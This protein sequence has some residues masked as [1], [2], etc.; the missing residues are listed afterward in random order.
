MHSLDFKRII[1]A[2]SSE[3]KVLKYYRPDLDLYIET[4]AS[5]KGIGMALLQS[6]NNECSSLYPIAYGSKTLTSAETR[7]MNIERELL[8][9]VGALEKFHYFTFG[10]PVVILTD[11]KPLIAISKKALVNAPTRLQ[12]LLLRMNNYNIVL[13]WIPGKEMIF[14]DH[15]SRNI[16]SKESNEPM[17]TGLEMKIQDIYLNASEDRC[18]SL[19]KE[20]EKDET[21]IA[22][23][24]MIL[25]GWP[26]KRDECP[27][28]LK[29]YWN[30][31]DELSVLDGLILKG[32]RIIIPSDCRDDVLEKL[33]EGHFGIDRTKLRARDSVYWPQINQD[34]ET[35]VKSC[36]KCQ[37]FSKRNNRDPDIP[38]EIPLVP[39]SLLEMDLFTLDDQTFLLVVDVTS[40]FPVV[41]ILSS[42]TANSVIN[43][44]KGIYCDFGLP[45]RVLTDNGP[46]FKSQKYI[47]F[48]EKLGISVEKSSAYNH[49]SVGSVERMVKTIKQIMHKNADN[50][51][52]AMLIFRATDIPGINKSPSE[53][54]NGRKFRTN[55]PMIDVHQKSSEAEIESLAEKRLSKGIKGQELSR[56]PVG[57]PILYDSNPDSTKIKCPTW[58]KGTG[59]R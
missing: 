52:L 30:Y 48:H 27:Q 57:T 1:E 23:K 24:N 15:L 32:T 13:Q 7:Y 25:R 3:G 28:N 44:L 29:S 41:R 14:A 6:E 58:L 9:V 19:A 49:Q 4:D 16:G 38:R 10:W 2:L 17:C 26:D 33:H 34:I 59:E 40:R 54:L 5:G 20:T 53:I 55:L 8:G 43:A 11:H 56:L 35:L 50:A 18:I 47:E 42:E 39:W 37:E 46:C 51:W 36:E 45:R 22:L 12:R 21:L 31:R